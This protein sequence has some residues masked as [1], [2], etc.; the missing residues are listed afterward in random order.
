MSLLQVN[1]QYLNPY[2][3]RE[4]QQVICHVRKI[5]KKLGQSY[6]R[7]LPRL[8]SFVLS[9][10][11]KSVRL[12]ARVGKRYLSRNKQRTYVWY[13]RIKDV[14]HEFTLGTLL[15]KLHTPKAWCYA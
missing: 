2:L 7:R 3:A 11:G 14:P 12:I 9:F 13:M 8:N 10:A 5:V 4:A 1:T 15:E 6:Y